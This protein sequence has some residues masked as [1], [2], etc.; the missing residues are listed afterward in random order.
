MRYD[1]DLAYFKKC[2]EDRL[3]LITDGQ[4]ERSKEAVPVE[5]LSRKDAMEQKAIAQAAVRLEGIEQQRIQSALARMHNGE[6][7]YCILCGE[8]ILEG[9]LRFDP[10]VATCIVCA[11]QE[12]EV[13]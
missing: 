13:R 1:I 7:G 6:Y 9:R 11:R 8:D 12:N 2:L 3:A 5:S 4:V 10:G